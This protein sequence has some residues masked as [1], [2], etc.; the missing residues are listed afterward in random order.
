M[1]Y[2]LTYLFMALIAFGCVGGYS[3]IKFL[4]DYYKED[5]GE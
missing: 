5:L 3:F 4:N 1:G 2:I